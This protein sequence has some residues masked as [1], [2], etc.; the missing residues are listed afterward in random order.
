VP[1]TD[2]VQTLIEAIRNDDD[3]ASERIAQACRGRIELMPALRPLLSDVDANR[4]WWAV[5]TLA[6]IGGPDAARLAQERLEDA[7]EATRCAA[8]LTLGELAASPAVPALANRLADISGWVRDSAADALAMIGE[9][10]LPALVRALT[11]ARQPVRVRAAAALRKALVQRLTGLTIN[12]YPPAYWPALNALYH[13]LNDPNRMVRQHAYEAID[14][15]GLFDQV[16]F[17]P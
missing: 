2:I 15:L 13:A 10:A 5:R 11:D 8:A 3:E 17:A 14:R 1:D 9:P 16:Y 6:L 7:D 4:R 12:D